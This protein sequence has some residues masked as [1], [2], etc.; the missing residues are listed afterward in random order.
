[1]PKDRVHQP[2]VLGPQSV[3]KLQMVQAG[4]VFALLHLLA[5]DLSLHFNIWK[6]IKAQLQGM[7]QQFQ[8]RLLIIV[9][10]LIYLFD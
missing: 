10:K 3:L 9:N 4:S 7:V 2:I 6:V 5:S 1:M 8:D